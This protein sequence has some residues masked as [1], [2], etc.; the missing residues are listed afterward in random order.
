MHYY[1]KVKIGPY[2]ITESMVL[3][4]K[5]SGIVIEVGEQVTH[6]VVG[7]RVVWNQGYPILPARLQD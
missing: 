1:E 3:G 4:H 6:L 7:D 5:A 2:I